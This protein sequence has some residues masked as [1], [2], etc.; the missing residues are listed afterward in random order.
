MKSRARSFFDL[1]NQAMVRRG[2][3]KIL[4]SRV[5]PYA[6]LQLDTSV[7]EPIRI[8]VSDRVDPF[9]RDVRWMLTAPGEP[10]GPEL[11]WS[12]A[13]VLFTVVGGLSR[14]FYNEVTGD[15]DSFKAV[16]ARMALRSNSGIAGAVFAD[17][18]YD[19]YRN[20]LIHS[21]GIHVDRDSPKDPWSFSA[22]R[23]RYVVAR[24]R[25]GDPRTEAEL[26]AMDSSIQ[27]EG[28]PPILIVDD[29]KVR[30]D[31][32]ALYCGARRTAID[33]ANDPT[34]RASALR[35]LTPW[36]T[37]SVDRGS[38]STTSQTPAVVLNRGF[39]AVDS[40]AGP[41]TSTPPPEFK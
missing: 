36:A 16:A 20:G 30:L 15:S 18:L 3:R 33:L 40:T 27:P 31:V 35:F 28:L 14:V 26:Q 9:L 10:G 32:D 7:P 4:Y 5:M 25:Q 21:S 11:N 6:A 39:T 41:V 13:V 12:I 19:V 29:I 23:E 17:T 37:Y 1:F 24:W 38:R 22:M 2:P 34:R 8:Y